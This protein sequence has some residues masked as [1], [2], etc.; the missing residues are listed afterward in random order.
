MS[1]QSI[2][3]EVLFNPKIQ[4]QRLDEG[5][6]IAKDWRDTDTTKE[7][8]PP[9]APYLYNVQEKTE[10]LIA[11][12]YMLG[13][14]DFLICDD[15][16]HEAA[17]YVLVQGDLRKKITFFHCKYKVSGR[18]RKGDET[19]PRTPGLNRADL[20]ELVDQAV[21]TAYWIRASNLIDRLLDRMSG[22][23]SLSRMVH[24]KRDDLENFAKTFAPDD[25][26]YAVVLV[27]PALS[28]SQLISASKPSQAEQL[29]IA[30]SDRIETD[31]A[32]D[33]KVWANT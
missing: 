5:T 30:V 31:Y 16:A 27:Q 21:R 28:R 13:P 1:G 29:L 4:T 20:T 7:A 23:S 12:E 18:K 2:R 32:A 25:W 10:L 8:D 3:D 9:E 14:Q 6:V 33:F 22:R 19:R 15:R 17:D 24:G 11:A 26:A